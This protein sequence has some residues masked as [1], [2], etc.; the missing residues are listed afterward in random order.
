MD[1]ISWSYVC[2]ISNA[3][4]LQEVLNGSD[5]SF[6]Y[7]CGFITTEDKHEFLSIAWKHYILYS[8]MLKLVSSEMD[9]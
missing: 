7:D 8:I 2:D 6:C 9:F 3:E 5:Y 4:E 1:G